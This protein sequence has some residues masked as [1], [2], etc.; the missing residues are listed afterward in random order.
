MWRVPTDKGIRMILGLGCDIVNVERLPSDLEHF[1]KR[2]LGEAEQKELSARRPTDKKVLS[3]LL[4][5]YYA[6]KEAF[7]KALGTGFRDGIYL[8]D[9]QILHTT[10]GKP[11]LHISGSA[12]DYLH[13]LSA[14]P[15]LHIT[16][17]DD[18]PYAQAVVII[19]G[20]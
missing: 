16:L 10:L 1:Q 6:G 2:I 4:A 8:K 15:R 20:E 19:E 5:K 3:S 7:A 12:L 17:S 13:R 14:A 9:I 18:F 11:E